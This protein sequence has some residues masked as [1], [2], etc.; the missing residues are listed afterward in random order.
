MR[1]RELIKRAQRLKKQAFARQSLEW[2][3]KVE[4][5]QI[6]WKVTSEIDYDLSKIKDITV[7]QG[8]RVALFKSGIFTRLLTLGKSTNISDTFDTVYFV[9]VAPQSEKIGIR[10]PDYPITSDNKSFGFSGNIVYKIMDDQV[11]IGNFITNLV[12]KDSILESKKIVRWLRDGLLFQVFKEILKDY[13]YSEFMNVERLSL[14]IEL[15]SRLGAELKDYGLE[16]IS[17]ELMHYTPAKEF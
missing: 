15:E 10:A 11:S 17:L 14:L 12:E 13:S 6:V 9:D 5:R 2:F 8:E 1:P 4:M 16:I 3:E 7:K